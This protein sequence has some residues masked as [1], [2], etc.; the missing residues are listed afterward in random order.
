MKIGV[1][2][3]GCGV[4]DG[5]EIQEAV[6]SLLAIQEVGAEAVCLSVNANQHHVVNH[7]T[8]EVM[9]ESRNMIVEAARIARGSVHEV[10]SYDSSQLDAVVIPGGFG[11]AKNFTTWAFDGPDGTILPEIQEF[12]KKCIS[13]KKPIAALCVSPVVL[14]LAFQHSDVHPTMTLGT[15][16]EKSPYDISAFSGGLTQT[17]VQAEMKTIHEISVDQN[18]KIVSAPCYMMDATIVEIRNNIQQAVKALIELI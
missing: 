13:D 10:S 2:L 16:K 5:A 17:G 11:S 1:L 6:F 4:Y 8:G 12:I 15:D 7:L 14:A 3:S 18:L 9:P